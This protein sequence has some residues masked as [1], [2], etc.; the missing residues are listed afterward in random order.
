MRLRTKWNKYWEVV[1]VE[2]LPGCLGECR[3]ST[4]Q[5]VLL[6]KQKNKWKTFIHECLH[7]F[8][9]DWDIGLTETQVSKLEEAIF[10]ALKLNK[11]FQFWTRLR[12]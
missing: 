1:E 5:I 12:D 6:K 3:P 8:S 4:R 9:F 10:R 11:I 2:E 7:A